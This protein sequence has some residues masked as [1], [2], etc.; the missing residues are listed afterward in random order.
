MSERG[1]LA[2][3]FDKYAGFK[4]RVAGAATPRREAIMLT[5]SWRA[6]PCHW[7]LPVIFFCIGLVY[8]LASPNFEA[9]DTE[10]HVGLID[11]IA[12]NGELPVQSPNKDTVYRQEASQPPLY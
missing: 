5:K 10:W 9:S 2:I 8:V 3:P 6:L 12:V 11:W 7:L 1:W 4:E